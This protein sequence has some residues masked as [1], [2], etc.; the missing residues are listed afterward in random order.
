MKELI[1]HHALTVFRKRPVRSRMQ[2]L[3]G[4]EVRNLWLP[5]LCVQLRLPLFIII[6]L[7]FVFLVILCC[8]W[9]RSLAVWHRL[10]LWAS[11]FITSIIIV[12]IARAPA[13]Q[14]LKVSS[15]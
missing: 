5:D 1:G 12:I 8:M 10:L 4:L 14:A 15:F 6:I 11:H 7:C 2:V 13:N 3:W 9:F